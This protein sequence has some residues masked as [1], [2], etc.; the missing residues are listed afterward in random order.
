MGLDFWVLFWSA[1]TVAIAVFGRRMWLQ[2][3]RQTAPAV[4]S[5]GGAP[6]TLEEKPAA[7]SLSAALQRLSKPIETFAEDAAHPRD[8]LECPEFQEAVRRLGDPAVSAEVV[9]QYALGGNPYLSSAAFEALVVRP[10]R[11][12]VLAAVTAQLN[13][14]WPGPMHYALRYFDSLDVRP[15]AGMALAYAQDWW[16]NNTALP[17]SFRESFERR[18]ALGDTPS[19]GE[20]LSSPDAGAIEAIDGVLKRIDHPF[21]ASLRAQLKT[22]SGAKIDERKLAGVGRFWTLADD[23]F[24]VEPAPWAKDLERA[25][26]AVAGNPPRSVVVTGDTR[27]GKSSFLR[28]LGARLREDGWRV[29][30]ASAAELM[31]GQTYI[32]QLELRIRE[33]VAELDAG[34]RVAWCVGDVAA[35]AESGAH[36]NQPATVFDQILPAVL[37]SRLVILGEASREGVTRLLQSRPSLRTQIEVYRLEPFADDDLTALAQALTKL[38]NYLDGPQITPQGLD[39]AL[40]LSRQYFS[41]QPA[42]GVVADLMKRSVQLAAA[43]DVAEVTPSVVIATLSQ[44]TGLP[45]TILDDK[46]P[47]DLAEVRRFFAER[48]IGQD[49]AV[50]TMV[51]RIAMLKAGL[52]DPH[53]PVGVFF[54]AGPTGTGK[55]ELAK[56]LAEFLFG[57]AERMARLDMSEFQS[58]ESMVKIVGERGRSSADSLVERVR[59]QPFSVILLDEFEK[60]HSNIWDLF[61]QVFDDGRL[62]DANGHVADFRHTIVILTSNL[63]AVAHRS[64][65]MGFSPSKDAFGDDQVLQAVGRAFRPEFV[66]RLDKV[67]VFRPLSRELMRAILTKELGHVLE[68][69]GLRNRDWAVEWEPSALDFLLDRGFTPEMGA[70]PLKRAI[71]QHLLAPLAATLVEHRF[72]EGDQFLFVRSNGHALEVEFVDPDA[73]PGAPAPS[74]PRADVALADLI[75][76]PSGTAAEEATLA[77]RLAEIEDALQAP[78]WTGLKAR[79]TAEA[80]ASDIW[81]RPDRSEVFTR[82]ALI[83]RVEEAGRT[84]GRL[85]R[86][87][88]QYDARA[89]HPSRELISRLALQLHLVELGMADVWADAPV[90]AVLSVEPAL[91]AAA[92]DAAQA[93]WIERL[94]RMYE[95]WAERRHMQ[96][97]TLAPGAGKTGPSLLRVTGF[98][99][100]RVLAA[101]RGL[102]VLEDGAG[103][104]V[105][106]TVARVRVAAGPREDPPRTSLHRALADLLD[107]AG[108]TATVTR[109][110]RETPPLVRDARAGWRTGRLDAVIGGDFDLIGL[111]ADREA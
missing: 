37:S 39:A 27:S 5:S 38:L 19:F 34:K 102:H 60:A 22:W 103:R 21:A 53:R 51:D 80:S 84:A 12:S 98:G 40:Q 52:V 41:A 76:Q 10:D 74:A 33:M 48:V 101:E 18:S 2:S 67:V 50:A 29:F 90:D 91:E 110:Y 49:D 26:R 17:D 107:A 7:E 99:A 4:P 11:A 77:D 85:G 55:T 109:R 108:E 56:T 43:S 93:A 23:A 104:T 16:P 20:H 54:F 94:R 58:P 105:R 111:M 36:S 96:F 70:R 81:D 44:I 83:D 89:H 8:N 3:R 66:N 57:S 100:F 47:V 31:A 79:L 63:G 71:D 92:D 24:L 65:G 30:E 88:A 97:E 73:E 1:A 95:A 35:F 82:L 86:R 72:P 78:E 68:R 9:R 25:E 13:R 87:A 6:A 46:E 106:R 32:G 61:L 64:A 42:P 45:Q 28:L 62:T 69:R 14:I 59:K 75:L 15:P